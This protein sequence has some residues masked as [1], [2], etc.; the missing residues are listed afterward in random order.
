VRDIARF[1]IRLYPAAWRERYGEELRA[2]VEDSRPGWASVFDLLRGAMR[3]RARGLAFAKLA[4]VLAVGGA[5]AGLGISFLVTPKYESTAMGEVRLTN[6]KENA[7]GSEQRL[8][9]VLE[10]IKSETTSRLSLSALIQDPKLDLYAT[11]RRNMPLEDVE[12]IMRDGMRMSVMTPR[13]GAA[14]SVVFSVRFAYP[15]RNKAQAVVRAWTTQMMDRALVKATE[16]VNA[17]DHALLE[18]IAHLQERIDYLERHFGVVSNEPVAL[19]QPSRSGGE[20][21]AQILA[22]ANLPEKP[23]S[24]N[25]AAFTALGCG[26]GFTLA[27]LATIYRRRYT[28]DAPQ[29]TS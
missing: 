1:A 21:V 23:K 10:Q 24:P 17:S 5:V 13:M 11:E 3:M 19:T 29:H 12:D 6:F 7:P 26:A 25:R 16:A 18:R 22:P 15:D 27:L 2:L 9:E 8:D 20:I 14:V 28:P 4:A